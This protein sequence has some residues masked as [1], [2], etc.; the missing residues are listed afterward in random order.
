MLE[1][2]E[3]KKE[4]VVKLKYFRKRNLD[5]LDYCALIDLDKII[6]E[7]DPEYKNPYQLKLEKQLN[8]K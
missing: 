7:Y 3:L 1:I 5:V 6:S 2:N 8:E 4:F